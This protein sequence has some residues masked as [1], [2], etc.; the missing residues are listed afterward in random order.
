MDRDGC[1]VTE[2]LYLLPSKDERDLDLYRNHLTDEEEFFLQYG[3]PLDDESLGFIDFHSSGVIYY[4]VFLKHTTEMV[5]YVGIK[6][7]RESDFAGELEYSIF[8][9][10]RK[11]GYC[12]EASAALLAAFFD[13]ALT[14]WEGKMAY[15]ETMPENMAA[16]RVLEKLG[17]SLKA[18]GF[19]VALDEEGNLNEDLSFPIV[20]YELEACAFHNRKTTA[21]QMKERM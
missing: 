7:Q 5:G 19:R 6:P 4:T 3:Y 12:T 10:H 15:A 20:S 8:R 18:K 1:I 17:F 16:C 14:G 21:S 2:W 11:R 13:G 9:E